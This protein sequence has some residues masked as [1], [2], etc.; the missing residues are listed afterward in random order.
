M[1]SDVACLTGQQ[2]VGL[3]LH[4]GP[5]GP[6]RRFELVRLLVLVLVDDEGVGLVGVAPF[7]LQI[8]A[9]VKHGLHEA[10]NLERYDHSSHDDGKDDDHAPYLSDR[11]DVPEAYR[12]ERRQAEVEGREHV[13]YGGVE[14]VLRGINE[15]GRYGPEQ[16]QR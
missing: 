3:D 9:E 6:L 4:V 14:D 5:V 10:R 12:H 1:R 2:D 11:G 13:R 7:G 15:A 8:P 16:E